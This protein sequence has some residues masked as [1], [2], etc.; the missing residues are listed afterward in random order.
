MKNATVV[1]LLIFTVCKQLWPKI[2]QTQGLSQERL[3]S[4]HVP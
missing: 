3:S 4:G 2:C 1:K